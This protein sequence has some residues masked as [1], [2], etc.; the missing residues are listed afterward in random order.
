MNPRS[1]PTPK[2]AAAFTLLE[3]V[4]VIA[5]LA[6]IAAVALPAIARA[7]QGDRGIQCQS[8]LG[9]LGAAWSLYSADNRELLPLNGNELVTNL[10]WC[11]GAVDLAG[12]FDNTNTQIIL[13]SLLGKYAGTASIYKCPADSSLS[14][15]KTGQPRVRSVSMNGYMANSTP[16]TAGA[17]VYLKVTDI[18]FHPPSQEFVILDERPDSIN[19]SMLV[20]DMSG[21]DP[22]QPTQYKIVDYPGSFHDGAGSFVFADGHTELHLWADSRTH[23]PLTDFIGIGLNVPQPNNP[24]VDWLQDH[25]TYTKSM[26]R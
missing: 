8:N 25:T 20:V 13:N 4:A 9:R 6:I 1:N 7:K 19:D 21:Y 17:Q 23:P 18:A 11:A 10:N 15:G 16:W 12:S 26:R 22:V 3:L 24:D 5:A 2:E 14:F